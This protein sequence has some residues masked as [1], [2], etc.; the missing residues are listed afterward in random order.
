MTI[1]SSTAVECPTGLEFRT[2]RDEWPDRFRRVVELFDEKTDWEAFER[3]RPGYPM[4]DTPYTLHTETRMPPMPDHESAYTWHVLWNPWPGNERQAWIMDGRPL[5][6]EET[7]HGADDPDEDLIASENDLV[8]IGAGEVVVFVALTQVAG[9]HS[10]GENWLFGNDA[11]KPQF[12]S[13]LEQ[14]ETEP[15]TDI[16][17]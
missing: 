14:L 8:R 1:P 6:P 7:V 3:P 13:V 4:E 16:E 11:F 10:R 2:P 9:L 5:R 17:V 12:D 15:I